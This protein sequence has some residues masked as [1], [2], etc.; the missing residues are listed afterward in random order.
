VQRPKGPAKRSPVRTPWCS[1]VDCHPKDKQVPLSCPSFRWPYLQSECV[2]P[3]RTGPSI[4]A[5][6]SVNPAS[7]IRFGSSFRDMGAVGKLPTIHSRA[8]PP[9]V[10]RS[11]FHVSMF[12]TSSI[13]RKAP[14]PVAYHLPC[15]REA[16][17]CSLWFG[18]AIRNLSV[19]PALFLLGH[20]QRYEN[21]MPSR[22]TP[23]N[24]VIIQVI[25]LN[26]HSR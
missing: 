2:S 19:T 13:C 11:W 18:E 1:V 21:I 25:S 24:L 9:V 6:S 3:I 22:L 10:W 14:G 5:S 20:F 8:S 23:Q 4:K 26:W 12:L 16:C 15:H 7:S 17:Y